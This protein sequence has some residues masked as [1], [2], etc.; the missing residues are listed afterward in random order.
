MGARLRAREYAGVVVG[1]AGWENH[2]RMGWLEAAG[3]AGRCAEVYERMVEVAAAHSGYVVARGKVILTKDFDFY[4]EG[5][6]AGY[7]EL[8][9][10]NAVRGARRYWRLHK[11]PDVFTH[12]LY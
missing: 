4:R 11:C 5:C 6:R 2:P 3:A 7:A 10:R 8:A 12:S 1:R 9:E